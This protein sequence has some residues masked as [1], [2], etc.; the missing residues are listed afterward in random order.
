[1]REEER[2]EEG[3]REKERERLLEIWQLKLANRQVSRF[4]HQD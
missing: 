3:K 4:W 2:Q 1:M